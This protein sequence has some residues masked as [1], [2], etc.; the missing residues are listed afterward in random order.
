M[1]YKYSA[2]LSP[3]PLVKLAPDNTGPTHLGPRSKFSPKA[4]LSHF[5]ISAVEEYI[6]LNESCNRL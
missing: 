5:F 4:P 6:I 2:S 1:I 3:Q